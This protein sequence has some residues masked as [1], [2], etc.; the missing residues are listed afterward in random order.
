MLFYH[1]LQSTHLAIIFDVWNV[2]YD[3]MYE[4][5]IPLEYKYQQNKFYYYVKVCIFTVEWHLK[6]KFNKFIG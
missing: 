2:M 3:V 1:I 6:C 4:K 5:N